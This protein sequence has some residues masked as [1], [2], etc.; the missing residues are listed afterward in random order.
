LRALPHGAVE[1]NWKHGQICQGCTIWDVW[2]REA[3]E[4]GKERLAKRRRW[5]EQR[6]REQTARKISAICSR[7]I[8]QTEVQDSENESRLEKSEL[9]LDECHI[10]RSIAVAS[11]A[12]LADRGESA[13]LK[14]KAVAKL[15]SFLDIVLHL[16]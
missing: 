16:I 12:G 10:Q 9:A 4:A 3:K 13:T 11:G 2:L 6:R 8:T 15:D 5:Q 14:S 7:C 1:L